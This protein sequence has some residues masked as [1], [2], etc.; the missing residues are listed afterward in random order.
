MVGLEQKQSRAEELNDVLLVFTG[1]GYF[2]IA[3]NPT[4]ST[5]FGQGTFTPEHLF[6][7]IPKVLTRY[8]GVELTDAIKEDWGG[9]PF[10]DLINGWKYALEKYPEVHLFIILNLEL[11]LMTMLRS[12]R[13]ALLPLVP[14]GEDMLSSRSF[15]SSHQILASDLSE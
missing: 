6:L 1:Q 12:I 4:G 11:Q 9:K 2:V 13:I 10:I 15:I 3:I 7:G 14:A 8:V 5:T